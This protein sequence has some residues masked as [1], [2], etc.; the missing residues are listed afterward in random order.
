MC[1]T[2]RIS[3]ENCT[4]LAYLFTYL[5]ILQKY[6][7]YTYTNLILASRF[8]GNHSHSVQNYLFD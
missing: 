8:F 3:A 6:D 4:K 2:L 5:F 1:P 7:L